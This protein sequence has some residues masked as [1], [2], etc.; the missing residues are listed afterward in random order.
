MAVLLPLLL[1][2]LL[3]AKLALIGWI[4]LR[5]SDTVVICFPALPEN[6]T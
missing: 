1:L 2:L 3:L 5:L 4:V 6:V